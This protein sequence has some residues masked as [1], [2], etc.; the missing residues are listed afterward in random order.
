[1]RSVSPFTNY[2]TRALKLRMPSSAVFVRPAHRMRAARSHQVGCLGQLCAVDVDQHVRRHGLH[3]GRFEV[4]ASVAFMARYV[5][6]LG[7]VRAGHAPHRV[8]SLGGPSGRPTGRTARHHLRPESFDSFNHGPEGSP[9]LRRRTSRFGSLTRYLGE[10]CRLSD[11]GLQDSANRLRL[12]APH[13]QP[14][15]REEAIS[16]GGAAAQRSP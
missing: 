9:A 15:T 7:D 11:E 2:T 3:E 4:P 10:R 13:R 5:Q 6:H 1:M 12:V 14:S 8:R 16:R